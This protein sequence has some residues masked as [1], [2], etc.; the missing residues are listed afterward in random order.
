[1]DIFN[2]VKRFAGEVLVE[3]YIVE[4]IQDIE[5][6]NRVP[7]ATAIQSWIFD[8]HGVEMPL[9]VIVK[10]IPKKEREQL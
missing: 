5:A 3:S 9:G 2:Y 8:V 10:Y 1:M 4:A 6:L 7:T